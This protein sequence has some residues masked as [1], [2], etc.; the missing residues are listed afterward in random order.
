MLGCCHRSALLPNLPQNFLLLPRKPASR[1]RRSHSHGLHHEVP[2]NFSSRK[3]SRDRSLTVVGNLHSPHGVVSGRCNSHRPLSGP[4]AISQ[5]MPY[6]GRKRVNTPLFLGQSPKIQP[7]VFSVPL[8]F[9]KESHGKPIPGPCCCVESSRE[10]P[11]RLTSRGS[12]GSQ[13]INYLSGNEIL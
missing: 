13:I 10:C 9:G 8:D 11:M 2:R 12:P 1:S 3:K 6:G 5:E 4:I 7:D